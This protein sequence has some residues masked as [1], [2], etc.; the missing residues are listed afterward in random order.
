MNIRLVTLFADFTGEPGTES[1]GVESGVI[2]GTVVA[3][4]VLYVH[5]FS[6]SSINYRIVI[7]A[8]VMVYAKL[9]PAFGDKIF[10]WRKAQKEV[11]TRTK[12]LNRMEEKRFHKD[13][14]EE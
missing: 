8:G 9:N 6:F 5:V 10:P 4:V 2:V 1:E 3:V 13:E 7:V 11:G 14:Y 12:D